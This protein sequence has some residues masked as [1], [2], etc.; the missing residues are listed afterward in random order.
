MYGDRLR[1]VT[2]ITPEGDQVTLTLDTPYDNLPVLLD[3]PIVRSGDVEA[4]G[5]PGHRPLRHGRRGTALN[6]RR[7]WWS[8]YPPAVEFDTIALSQTSTPSEIRDQFEFG[9]TDLVCRGPG[10]C[11]LRGVPLR[12]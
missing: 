7:D 9:Q 12:L 8:E 11:R 4:E 5:T 10:L 1:H 6:R 3:I 2:K